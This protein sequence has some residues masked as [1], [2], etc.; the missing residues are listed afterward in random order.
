MLRIE[1]DIHDN[2][3]SARL[4]VARKVIEHAIHIVGDS[5]MHLMS[6]G[7]Q[8]TLF[9]LSSSSASPVLYNENIHSPQTCSINLKL[10]PS[11]CGVRFVDQAFACVSQLVLRQ[12][13]KWKLLRKLC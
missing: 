5:R 3:D 9:A 12:D 13:L 11:L 7:P 1:I 8:G 2:T 6:I 10:V 4:N